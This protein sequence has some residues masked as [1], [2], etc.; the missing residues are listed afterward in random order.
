MKIGLVIT[1]DK[2][3]DYL[4]EAK[5]SIERGHKVLEQMQKLR[6]EETDPLEQALI[7]MDMDT[8]MAH[9]DLI[10]QQYEQVLVAKQ[11]LYN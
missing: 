5:E 8:T 7:E 2:I 6:D 10:E 1:I 4:I 11:V 3:D 9:L